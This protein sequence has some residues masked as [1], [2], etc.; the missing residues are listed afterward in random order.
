M[1]ALTTR[2]AEIL[3]WIGDGCPERDWPDQGHRTTAEVLQAHGLVNVKNHGSG[4][5]ATVTEAGR[6][7][8]ADGLSAQP[9]RDQGSDRGH[10]VVQLVDWTEDQAPQ[11]RPVPVPGALRL[12]LPV[13][14][15]LAAHPDLLDISE[16]SRHRALLLIQAMDEECRR[17]GYATAHRGRKKGFDLLI[18]GERVTVLVSEEMEEVS[19]VRPKTPARL[20]YDRQRTR[21]VAVRDWSGRLAMTLLAD[22]WSQPRWAD[23]Q[24]WTLDSR[25]PLLLERAVE[26]AEERVG[27]R[28]RAEQAKAERWRLWK[29]YVPRARQAYIDELNRKRL[30]RHL[31]AHGEAQTMR[32][33]ADAVAQTASGMLPGPEREAAEAW[34]AWIRDEADRL[35]P[36]LDQK[37]LHFVTPDDI[38]VWEVSK[39]MPNG[40]S[41]SGP[42]D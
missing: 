42:P 37:R 2:Q 28:A 3:A 17:R 14:R 39:Y 20:N 9:T 40:W 27:A 41:A 8:L 6:A 22:G 25:L 35:D 31:E 16:T 12:D 7:V 32:S 18:A 21:L 15:H 1:K 30:A 26:A 13:V 36:S 29:E 34:A 23:C 4:W 5:T 33:Y 10:F 11:R 19:R 38:P 24:E